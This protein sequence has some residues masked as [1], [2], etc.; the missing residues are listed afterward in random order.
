MVYIL[1]KK[2]FR[3]KV[4]IIRSKLQR[5]YNIFL[6]L[7]T[8]GDDFLTDESAPQVQLLLFHSLKIRVI[9]SDREVVL[10]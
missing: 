8:A 4:L 10:K 9:F 6:T 1:Y 2:S 5:N 7:V 3:S